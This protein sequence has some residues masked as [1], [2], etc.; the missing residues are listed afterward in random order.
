MSMKLY[1]D[2]PARAALQV[3]SDLL[4]VVWVVLW[5]RVGQAVHDSIAE[6]AAPATALEGGASGLS[7]RLD[8][9]G[10]QAGRVPVVGDRLAEP[11]HQAG[12]AA[13]GVAD[14]GRDLALRLET[15]ADQVGLLTALVPIV[16]LVGVWASVRISFAR[17]AAATAALVRSPAG[18][19]LLALRALSG[20]STRA[21][22][23]VHPDPAGAWRAG[24]AA[25][26]A[27]LA[28][29]EAS[30]RGVR[31]RPS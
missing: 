9:A 23:A 28:A 25:A 29:L 15:L 18:A 7:D 3:V 2:V 1:A 13:S 24:D 27:R 30:R 22:V 20:G 10:Q 14:A 16:V 12:D 6:L 31:P 4:V 26:V 17:R 11:L 21:L 8:A 5:V 19:N